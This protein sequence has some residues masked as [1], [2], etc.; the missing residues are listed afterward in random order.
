[1]QV[2]GGT[3]FEGLLVL[4]GLRLVYLLDGL[5]VLLEVRDGVLPG[6]QALGEEAGGLSE[7]ASVCDVKPSP[8]ATRLQAV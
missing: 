3:H 2:T 7:S 6:L 5:D 1:M 8:I 4:L